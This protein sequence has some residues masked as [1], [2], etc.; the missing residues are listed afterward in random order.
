MEFKILKKYD[1][2]FAQLHKQR[3]SNYELQ[4][5]NFLQRIK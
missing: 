3:T 5:A 1:Y 2:M 4:P